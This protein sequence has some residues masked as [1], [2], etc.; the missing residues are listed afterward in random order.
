MVP[1]ETSLYL[2]RLVS[3][4]RAHA[5]FESARILPNPLDLEACG[6]EDRAVDFVM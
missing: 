5:R 3:H 2:G 1:D 6:R 4:Y